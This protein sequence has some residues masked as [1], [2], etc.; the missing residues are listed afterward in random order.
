MLAARFG[1]KLLPQRSQ[2]NIFS[3]PFPTIRSAHDGP[4]VQIGCQR[5]HRIR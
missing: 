1:L 2:L 3:G 4:G 5:I